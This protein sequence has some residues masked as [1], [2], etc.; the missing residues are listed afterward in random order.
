M[1]DE[2]TEKYNGVYSYSLYKGGLIVHMKTAAW[3]RDWV[4]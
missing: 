1:F 4:W 3:C 2:E